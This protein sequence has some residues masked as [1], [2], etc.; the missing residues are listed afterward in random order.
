MKKICAI[1][2]AR[3]DEFY[4]RKWVE[5]YGTQLGREN[6]RVFFDGT[7][8]LVPDFCEGVYTELRPRVEG[9][10][11][12]SDKGRINYLSDQAAQ[13]FAQGYDM[14]IGTDVDEFIVV[15]PKLGMT[16]SEYLSSK[17]VRYCLSA[18][19][20]DVGQHL[21]KE[22][23][24]DASKP[25]LVQRS[26]GYLSSRYTK[27]SVLARPL[28]WGSGF[29]RVKGHNFHIAK[30]L[31]L[32]HLGG[33][34]YERM[35]RQLQNSDLLATG[36][37]KHLQRRAKTIHIVTRAKALEWDKTVYGMRFIQQWLR[38]FFAWNKP[39]NPSY[40]VV[41]RIPDRFKNVL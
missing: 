30:D 41:V 15:D 25:F 13:L 17:D 12:K 11:A 9:N 38:Q 6:L 28:R 23:E 26:Y 21:D 10:V 7:D 32:F 22:V 5:Y 34:D 19:G 24:I 16:L 35:K 39:W 3:N 18:L 31:Y 27:A 20:V 4:L 36:W 14:V 1:T 33:F 40:K 29:H 37:G 8:Q 2:M